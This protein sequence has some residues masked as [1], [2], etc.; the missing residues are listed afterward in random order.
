MATFVDNDSIRSRIKDTKFNRKIAHNI[1]QYK[2]YVDRGG[3][4]LYSKSEISDLEEAGVSDRL[5][6]RATE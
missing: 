1:Y 5:P 2:Q 3:A 6:P 4:Q